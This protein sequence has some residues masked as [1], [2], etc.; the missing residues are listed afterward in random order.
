MHSN[1]R[2]PMQVHYL[3]IFS[4]QRARTNQIFEMRLCDSLAGLGCT[5]D[6]IAPYFYRSDNIPRPLIHQYFGLK[7]TFKVRILPTFFK[8]GM[9][10]AIVGAVLFVYHLIFAFRLLFDRRRVSST[11]VISSNGIIMIPHLLLKSIFKSKY[12]PNH[13]LLCWEA[14]CNNRLYRW[15]YEKV[16]GVFSDNSSVLTSISKCAKKKIKAFLFHSPVPD[17]M[18]HQSLTRLEAR[19]RLGIHLNGTPLVVYTGKLYRG[20]RELEYMLLAAE[21]LVQYHFLFTGGQQSVVDYYREWCAHRGMKNV[22]FTGFLDNAGEVRYYQYAANVLLSYYTSQDHLVEYQF[23]QKITEYMCTHN[24]IVT[25]D[26]PAT[27]DVLST[28][29]C[30]IVEPENLDSLVKGIVQAVLKREDSER[31]AQKAFEDVSKLTYSRKTV[32]LLDFIKS[33][34]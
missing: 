8:D 28:S 13:L 5:V 2:G 10:G 3:T 18:V 30:V 14:K 32:E 24:P 33:L 31:I 1:S 29:N 15:I 19:K 6:I 11:V 20:Q 12:S 34:D 27:R 16:D 17:E 9:S 21:R 23:P 22:T 25:P 4:L 26:Y 7:N